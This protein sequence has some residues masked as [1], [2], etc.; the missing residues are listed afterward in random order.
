MGDTYTSVHLPDLELSG[1]AGAHAAV[2]AALIDHGIITPDQDRDAVLSAYKYHAVYRPGPAVRGAYRDQRSAD[3]VYELQTN[4]IGARVGQ[5][6]NVMS[7]IEVDHLGCPKCGSVQRDDLVPT[8]GEALT[9]FQGSGQM[10]SLTCLSCGVA[11]DVRQWSGLEQ[12]CFSYLGYEFWNWPP[13]Q[14][15]GWTLDI[16]QVIAK[17]ARTR[18]QIGW[19]HV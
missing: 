4:G 17:A 18:A 12:M 15:D 5:S 6:Y 19:G 13:L 1:I 7:I 14:L 9:A 10:P 2:T 3:N 11:S 16:P 8:I